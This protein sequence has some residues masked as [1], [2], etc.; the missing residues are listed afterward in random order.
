MQSS[1]S[2]PTK[3]RDQSIDIL[4]FIGIALIILAHT[5]PPDTILNL[6]CFDVS[7]MLFVS[8]L[9]LSKRKYDFS[10][11]YFKHRTIRLLLPVYFFLTIYFILAFTCQSIGFDFGINSNHVIGS[12]LLQDGIGFVW[13][14]RVFLLIA[15]VTPFILFLKEKTNTAW[16][17]SISLLLVL[18]IDALITNGVGMQ[19]LFVRDYLYYAIGYSVPF[20][21]GLVLPNLN[22]KQLWIVLF[23]TLALLIIKGLLILNPAS[24]EFSPTSLLIFNN[25]KYPPNSYYILYGVLMS[26]LCYIILVKFETYRYLLLFEFIGCNTIWIYLYHIPLIQITGKLSLGWPIRYLMVFVIAF[27]LTYLQVKLITMLQKKYIW[28]SRLQ[29]LKG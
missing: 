5:F 13:I 23:G 22:L 3:K 26:T 11:S 25:F 20:I 29:F 14:I 8:G 7:L 15:L 24:E 16:M 1:V 10:L 4:R 6:R 27:L 12:Y 17:F 9:T 21:V 18:L 19:N 28:A 2:I